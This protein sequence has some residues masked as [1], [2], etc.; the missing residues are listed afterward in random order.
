MTE[1][2]IDE[3]L[4]WVASAVNHHDDKWM[5]A[6][7]VHA[8]RAILEQHRRFNRVEPIIAQHLE[9]SEHAIKLEAIRAFVE[10]VERRAYLKHEDKLSRIYDAMHEELAAMEKDTEWL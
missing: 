5:T 7:M 9:R 10:R 2:T 6:D 8:I 3:M 4:E 1:P